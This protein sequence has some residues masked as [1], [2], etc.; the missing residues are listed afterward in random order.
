MSI[1]VQQ[2]ADR[3]AELMES[4]LGIKGDHLSGKL[5]VAA[6]YLPK[7]VLGA[8]QFLALSSDQAVN[9]TLHMHL[10]PERI[11]VAYDL[12]VRHLKPLGVGARRA[13]LMRRFVATLVVTLS[14]CAALLVAVLFWRGFL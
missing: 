13:M 3:V 2:M 9:P 11:A 5:P 4:R 7:K 1:S 12:C 8:A 14:I 6:R 10:D